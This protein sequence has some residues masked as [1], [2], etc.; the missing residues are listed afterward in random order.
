MHARWEW[1]AKK[2]LGT[3]N[4][5]SLYPTFNYTSCP[6]TSYLPSSDVIPT[7][8][9]E[10]WTINPSNTAGW[11]SLGGYVSIELNA[12][13]VTVYYALQNIPS[14]P[15]TVSLCCDSALFTNS[16]AGLNTRRSFPLKQ[17]G[18]ID[19]GCTSAFRRFMVPRWQLSFFY[20]YRASTSFIGVIC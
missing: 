17:A 10:D 14:G 12:Q 5:F 18:L 8:T 19:A 7:L 9:A 15:G 6:P 20:L 11:T 4:P 2:E 1:K 3:C 13:N 16:I